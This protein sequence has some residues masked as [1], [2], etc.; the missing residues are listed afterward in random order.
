MG[1]VAA[2]QLT[3]RQFAEQ[4]GADNQ[5]D[6]HTAVGRTLAAVAVDNS[7]PAEVRLQTVSQCHGRRKGRKRLP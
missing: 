3:H 2:G 1:N 4:A 6:H 7:R 5:V